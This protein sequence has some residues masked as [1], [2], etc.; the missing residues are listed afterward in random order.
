MITIA[1][2]FVPR[3]QLEL[4]LVFARAK[5]I[6][7][8]RGFTMEV[9]F[10]GTLAHCTLRRVEGFREWTC[11]VAVDADRLR[12]ARHPVMILAHMIADAWLEFMRQNDCLLVRDW[13]SLGSTAPT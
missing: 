6:A 9:R 10:D 7:C 5:R 4:S 8:V 3:A 1:N 2:D 12:D 11:N 13:L